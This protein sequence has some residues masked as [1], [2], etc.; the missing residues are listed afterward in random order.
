M[1][2]PSCVFQISL[3]IEKKKS[4]G[5]GRAHKKIK[6]LAGPQPIRTARSE[7]LWKKARNL[8][9]SQSPGSPATYADGSWKNRGLSA[10]PS[11]SLSPPS[12]SASPEPASTRELLRS[13]ATPVF[14]TV[15]TGGGAFVSV[16]LPCRAPAW[17]V[18]REGENG[19]CQAAGSGA[20]P[21]EF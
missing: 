10:N 11:A 4:L 13:N 3:M 15:R 6:K 14:F 2:P 19:T 18:N 17:T 21:G 9:F 1:T 8:H 5:S 20:V 7:S 12:S 16:F